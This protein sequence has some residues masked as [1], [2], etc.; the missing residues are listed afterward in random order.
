MHNSPLHKVSTPYEPLQRGTD[1][2]CQLF[3][4]LS[5]CPSLCIASRSYFDVFLLSV[6]MGYQI[7][8]CALRVL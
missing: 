6:G 5:G 4:P 1:D 3:F 7:Y 2:T 8:S